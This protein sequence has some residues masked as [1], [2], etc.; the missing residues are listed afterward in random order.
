MPAFGQSN[1][2]TITAIAAP[3]PGA[4]GDTLRPRRRGRGGVVP[5]LL[6]SALSYQS[7]GLGRCA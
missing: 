5:P 2:P 6:S 1:A 3:R 7:V 4:P